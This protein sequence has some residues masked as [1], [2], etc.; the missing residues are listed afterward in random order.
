MKKISIAAMMAWVAI[1]CSYSQ[2]VDDQLAS[3]IG[4]SQG[5]EAT[6]AGY[7]T[8]MATCTN[9]GGW[10]DFGTVFELMG[11]GSANNQYYFGKLIARFK[12]QDIAPGPATNVSL[13]LLDSNIGAENIK[14]IGNGSTIDIFVRINAAYT[15]MHYRRIVGANSLITLL[16]NEPLISDLPQG[17]RID[18]EEWEGSGNKNL[19]GRMIQLKDGEQHTE[20]TS[21]IMGRCH[22]IVFGAS[23]SKSCDWLTNSMVYSSEAGDYNYGA[24]A[25][26]YVGNGGQLDFYISN[27]STGV[28]QKVEWGISK[29]TILRNGNVGIGKT[30][31]GSNK[32]DVSGTIR[33]T[34]IKV[35]AATTAQLNVDG[36]LH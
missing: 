17:R 1:F 21:D 5:T 12:R 11:N 14:G 35:E 22:E 20:I 23:R 30:P 13:V 3:Q 32:L 16:N 18:C 25:I 36:T 6:M 7:W 28:G 33:A 19:N 27:Q 4:R 2:I 8:R 10:E 26:R 9:N 29:M 24:G 34:E 31:E 15:N